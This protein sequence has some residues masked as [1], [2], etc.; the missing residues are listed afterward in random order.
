[1]GRPAPGLV[2]DKQRRMTVALIVKQDEFDE[3]C[4]HVRKSGIV[5]FDT[6]F[7]SEHTY[8]PQLCL[9]QFATAEQTAAVD[10]FEV[11]DL[12][13]W[14]ELMVDDQTTVI[15]HG[16][17]AEIRFCLHYAGAA[18]ENSSTCRWPRGSAAAAI[19]WLTPRSSTA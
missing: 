13:K 4:Q 16:G 18:P 8:Q 1:M 6:E 17:Q 19:R 5:A 10:P 9:L 14:W 7:I 15:S 3:F 12:S 2:E 11:K